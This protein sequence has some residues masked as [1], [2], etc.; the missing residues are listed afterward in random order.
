MVQP[1]LVVGM[2]ESCWVCIASAVVMTFAPSL[3]VGT[4]AGA[5]H[6]RLTSPEVPSGVLEAQDVLN[7]YEA[8]SRRASAPSNN[9]YG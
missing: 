7:E 8:A 3:Q 9:C 5:F 2:V 1:V 4:A 6:V